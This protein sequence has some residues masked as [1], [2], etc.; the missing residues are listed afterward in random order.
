MKLCRAYFKLDKVDVWQF[1]YMANCRISKGKE[2][3]REREKD[4]T[5][6]FMNDQS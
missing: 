1:V 6:Q 4:M 2:R 3:E 5:E